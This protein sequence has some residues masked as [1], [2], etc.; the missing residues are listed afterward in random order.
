MFQRK[1]AGRSEGS[2]RLH[3]AQVDPEIPHRLLALIRRKVHQ[4]RRIENAKLAIREPACAPKERID[5][6]ARLEPLRLV[7]RDFDRAIARRPATCLMTNQQQAGRSICRGQAESLFS[8]EFGE[9]VGFVWPGRFAERGEHLG[10]ELVQLAR[11][12]CIQA[13]QLP[14]HLRYCVADPLRG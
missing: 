9:F 5:C 6:D 2:E 3:A 11:H 8:N 4:A 12:P 1:H 14:F 10:I 13:V 7:A